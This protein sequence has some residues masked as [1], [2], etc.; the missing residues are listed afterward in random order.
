MDAAEDCEENG[1]L[2]SLMSRLVLIMGTGFLNDSYTGNET[3]LKQLILGS[4]CLNIN[5][6]RKSIVPQMQIKVNALDAMII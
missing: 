3:L 1:S 2:Q 4:G 6:Y 5:F